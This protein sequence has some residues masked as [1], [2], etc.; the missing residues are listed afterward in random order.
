M[1]GKLFGRRPAPATRPA[2]VDRSA[3]ADVAEPVDELEAMLARA[4]SVA[5]RAAEQFLHLSGSGDY[6]QELVGESHYQQQLALITGGK[7]ELSA[8]IEKTAL[9]SFDDENE[10]DDQAVVV[11]IEGLRVGFFARDDARRY[12]REIARLA[13]GG[14]V[15]V[16]GALITGGWDDG[17]SQGSFGVRL[18]IDWPLKSS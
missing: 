10:H 3:D 18:D 13:N 14:E 2:S 8:E 12:R 17:L 1:F 16:C 15:M 9:V 4:R 11:T 6:E 7:E 5:E